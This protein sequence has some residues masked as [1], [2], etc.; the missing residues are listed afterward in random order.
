MRA[1]THGRRRHRATRG[2]RVL[3]LLD[4]P[5]RFALAVLAVLRSLGLGPYDAGYLTIVMIEQ[6]GPILLQD[7]D[8][9]LV[10]LSARHPPSAPPKISSLFENRT[11]VLVRKLDRILGRASPAERDWFIQSTGL[12]KAFIYF[13]A[14]DDSAG[15]GRVLDMLIACGWRDVL[16]QV[17]RRIDTGLPSNRPEFDGALSHASRRLLE[18]EREKAKRAKNL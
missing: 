5:Q 14:A 3:R 10:V 4:D 12:I 7:L 9:L 8:G 15:R 18:I 2:R 6:D 13:A 11:D 1:A 16:T 17:G